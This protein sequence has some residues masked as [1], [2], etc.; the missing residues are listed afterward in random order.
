MTV[1]ILHIFTEGE[2][3]YK[4]PKYCNS[5]DSR[6]MWQGAASTFC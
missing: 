2:N 4:M 3:A 5:V 6:L 1:K